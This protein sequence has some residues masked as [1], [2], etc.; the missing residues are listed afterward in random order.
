MTA[1]ARRHRA[2]PPAAVLWDMDG[3]I[4]DT[5]PYWI[6]TEYELVAEFGGHWS[7]EKAHSL[8]GLDLRDSAA[9]IR[10]RGGV[11][12]PIDDIVN[13]LL[14]GVIARIAERI[15]WRPG[16]RE[17]LAD[18]R[19][20]GVPTALVTMS[21][22]RFAEAVVDVLPPGTFTTLV[23][24]DEVSRGKPDPEPY[25]V[26]AAALGVDPRD[27]VAIEDS[28]TGVRSAVAAGC[29]T[30]AVPNVV[31]IP[32]GD[33]YER[34]ESLADI[35][36]TDLGFGPP[37]RGA[38]SRRGASPRRRLVGLATALGLA[39]G[40]GWWATRADTPPGPLATVPVS[41][42][43]PY[44]ALDDA[45]PTVE[46]HGALVAEFSPFWYSVRGAQKVGL[47]GT[48]EPA[49]VAAMSDALRR[50]GA[51][52]IPSVVDEMPAGGMAALLA[53]PD[54][55]GRHVRTLVSL[56]TDGDFDGIDIDYETFAWS[57]GRDTWETT[58]PHWVAFVTE[59]GA[60]LD[61]V[62]RRLVVTIPPVYP[63]SAPER[64]AW[65]YD[66][67]AIAAHVD[68]LRVMAYDYSTS[69]AGPIA[70]LAWV[71]DVAQGMATLVGDRS[72]VV[73]G[74]ATYG[75]NWVVSTSGTCPESASGTVPVTQDTAL[76]VAARRGAVPVHDP[77]AG[78]SW[79]A[80]QLTVADGGLSCVQSREVH[81]VDEQGVRARIDIAREERL[82]GVALWAVGFDS[83]PLWPA[84]ADLI[85]P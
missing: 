48:L 33:G 31:D 13:R 40:G 24:G 37:R 53:D 5:E 70:P 64:G 38:S 26:A 52:V 9:I 54:R 43:V 22:R 41:A 82:G 50:S 11:D 77:V 14:D 18:L 58:R 65:V 23:T 55:R 28:P 10:D 42:W 68:T 21:W 84:I 46:R 49:H 35:D 60:A 47:S 36:L 39:V 1:P 59:L 75:R 71:R 72:K 20:A 57:D 69:A 3:T 8:V 25:L 73:L 34:I 78:E 61:A 15:P 81:W 2:H 16:A 83:D 29:R 63:D 4:V 66:P 85:T 56:V 6:A 67:A 80:Y 51:L 74:V 76:A 32:E 27:C 30:L 79:F 17:L 7:D 19:R 45:L 44:W 12:L 62:D